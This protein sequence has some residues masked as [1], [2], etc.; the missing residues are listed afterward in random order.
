MWTLRVAC[1]RPLRWSSRDAGLSSKI[2]GAQITFEE[3]FHSSAT[4][5]PLPKH[6][7]WTSYET[8]LPAAVERFCYSER[9]D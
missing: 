5:S 2:N 7:K 3:A 4:D 6:E 1:L 8:G 9:G